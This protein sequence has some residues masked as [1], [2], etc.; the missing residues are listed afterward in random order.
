VITYARSPLAYGIFMNLQC[1][2]L[3]KAVSDRALVKFEQVPK[4]GLSQSSSQLTVF[5]A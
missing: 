4:E 5:A 2:S 1:F 3:L